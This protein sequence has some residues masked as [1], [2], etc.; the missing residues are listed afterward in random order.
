MAAQQITNKGSSL[1]ARQNLLTQ[2]KNNRLKDKS[3]MVNLEYLVQCQKVTDFDDSKQKTKAKK[4]SGDAQD[5]DCLSDDSKD[6]EFNEEEA[7]K[8]QED[9]GG[10]WDDEE[11]VIGDGDKDQGEEGEE[12]MDAISLGTD[13]N[14]AE[15]A[16]S[17]S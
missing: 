13:A 6:S 15:K 14:K 3:K 7:L 16:M 4:S 11:N 9:A 17:E 8:A 5:L 12:E 10:I 1:N 2:L